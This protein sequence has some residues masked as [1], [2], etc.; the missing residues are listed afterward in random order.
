MLTWVVMGPARVLVRRL[1]NP[2]TG[3][4][5][6]IPQAPCR[7]VSGCSYPPTAG[8]SDRSCRD[9]ITMGRESGQATAPF[10]TPAGLVVM[11][12]YALTGVPHS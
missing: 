11:K 9:V 1:V 5:T 2:F 8:P 10:A 6:L 4:L 12:R 3:C 7:S